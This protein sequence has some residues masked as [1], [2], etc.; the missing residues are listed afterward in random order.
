M[1]S[2][3]IDQGEANSLAQSQPERPAEMLP[4]YGARPMANKVLPIPEG[5]NRGRTIFRAGCH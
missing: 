2:S 4:G 3:K 5:S 1:D